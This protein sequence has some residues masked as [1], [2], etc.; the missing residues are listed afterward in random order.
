MGQFFVFNASNSAIHVSFNN[1]SF[2]AVKQA[3]NATWL[4][5]VPATEPVFVNQTNP[6]QGEIGLGDNQMA[7]Y[8]DTGGPGD[9][10]KFTLKVPTDVVVSSVQLYLFWK[11]ATSVAWVALNQ[12]QPFQVSFTTSESQKVSVEH[13]ALVGAATKYTVSANL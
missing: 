3:E 13:N 4:P 2:I 7:V 5:S 8:P 1:G 9:T 6:G 11:S 10:S 12:G